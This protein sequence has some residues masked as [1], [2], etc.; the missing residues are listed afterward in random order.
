MNEWTSISVT[1][2][3]ITQNFS[4]FRP[5]KVELL[6]RQSSCT[7]AH[8]DL[9]VDKFVGVVYYVEMVSTEQGSL[10]YKQISES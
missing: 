4:K 5:L 10:E 8:L 9:S 2:I 6:L 3:Q 1:I 7:E